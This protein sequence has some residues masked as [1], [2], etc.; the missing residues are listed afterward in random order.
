MFLL[1]RLLGDVSPDTSY[2]WRWFDTASPGHYKETET[3]GST[4]DISYTIVYP[5]STVMNH[6]LE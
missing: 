2:R 3:N 4:T 5:S 6:Y 1:I